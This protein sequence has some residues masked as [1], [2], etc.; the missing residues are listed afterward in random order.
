MR[1][2]INPSCASAEVL[3]TTATKQPALT[4]HLA[5]VVS[6]CAS[7]CIAAVIQSRI[8]SPSR[9][10]WSFLPPPS[11][12]RKISSLLFAVTSS[13]SR[14]RNTARP[15]DK[16]GTR[17]GSL[18]LWYSIVFGLHETFSVWLASRTPVITCGTSLPTPR[19]RITPSF[20]SCMRT[21]HLACLCASTQ[22]ACFP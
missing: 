15:R 12:K 13:L 7:R 10:S 22:Y 3:F 20:S 2:D 19:R 14:K 17:L 4:M 11:L 5:I 16:G 6:T 21:P 18:V 1:G 8:G 9:S